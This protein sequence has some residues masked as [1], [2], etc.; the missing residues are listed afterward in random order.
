[1]QQDLPPSTD[2]SPDREERIREFLARHGGRG[3]EPVRN[4]ELEPGIRGFSEVQAADGYR[5]RCDWSRF[6]SREDMRFSEIAPPG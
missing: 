1:M 2:T 5:L 4:E 3:A 6:G